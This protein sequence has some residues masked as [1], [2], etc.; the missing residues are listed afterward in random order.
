MEGTFKSK[1]VL[2]SLYVQTEKILFHI[3]ILYERGN[4]LWIGTD[5]LLL[6][7]KKFSDI[8]RALSKYVFIYHVFI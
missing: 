7:Q 1:A 2:T 6:R 3:A 8:P 5:N 4:F